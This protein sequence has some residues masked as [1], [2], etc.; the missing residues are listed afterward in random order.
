M[1]I[2]PKFREDKATQ[3]ACFLIKKEGGAINYMKLIK[4]LYLADRERI[5]SRGR[6][7]TFDTYFSLPRGP[8]LSKTLNLITNEED[9]KACAPSI[10]K[11]HISEPTEFNVRL[12]KQNCQINSLSRAEVAVLEEVYER[13]G[14]LNQWQ[15]V[16]WCHDNLTEWTDPEGSHLPIYYHD[17]L[18]R[19]GKTPIEAHE[20]EKELQTLAQAEKILSPK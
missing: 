5:L 7:I 3:A 20:I 17:I 2:Q 13:F 14:N 1:Q 15:L 19:G 9:P 6:P 4:L 18:I 16:D 10:W 12:A 11:E 8:I